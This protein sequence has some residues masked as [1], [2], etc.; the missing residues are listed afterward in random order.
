VPTRRVC[1]GLLLLV[2]ALW[3]SLLWWGPSSA[4]AFSLGS[5][6]FC[7]GATVQG[8]LT[9]QYV[10]YTAGLPDG[11]APP[12][13]DA[14]VA[15]PVWAW[16]YSVYTSDVSAD[17]CNGAPSHWFA[18]S[19]ADGSVSWCVDAFGTCDSNPATA[20]PVPAGWIVKWAANGNYDGSNGQLALPPDPAYPL[21]DP[22][23]GPSPSPSD[24]PSPA[25]SPSDSPGPSPS[26][27]SAAVMTATL[28]NGQYQELL[29]GLALLVFLASAVAVASFGRSGSRA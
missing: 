12:V 20:H 1:S 21:S 26:P 29:Y 25:P 9:V 28:D 11:G 6:I 4:S 27:T 23:A 5:P 19:R 22:P 15:P 2:T 16:G 10:G 17:P 14:S 13:P 3:L 18:W 7:Q 8:G 24:S